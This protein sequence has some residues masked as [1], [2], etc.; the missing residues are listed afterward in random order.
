LK[1]CSQRSFLLKQLRCQGLSRQQLS[2]IFYATIIS[3]SRYALPAWADFLT[4]EAEVLVPFSLACFNM[5][6]VV[7]VIVSLT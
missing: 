6:I 4:K 7:I 5:D 1:Q 3:R 2:I